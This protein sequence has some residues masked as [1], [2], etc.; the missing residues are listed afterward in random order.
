MLVSGCADWRTASA[1]R[2]ASTPTVAQASRKH[3][4]RAASCSEASRSV[5]QCG[6]HSAVRSVVSSAAWR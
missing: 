5:G 1:A 3:M 2:V 6:A 4:N